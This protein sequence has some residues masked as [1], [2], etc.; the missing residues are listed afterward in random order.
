MRY[1]LDMGHTPASPGASGYIDEVAEDRKVGAKL[2]GLLLN[3]GHAV[4]DVTAPHTMRY[5]DETNYRVSAANASGAD[6]FISLHFNAGGGSGPEALYYS[7]DAAGLEYAA[8]ISA[9]LAA[10][11]GLRD[12][13]AKPRTQEVAVIRDT[14][15]T[16]V[17]V[18]VCFVDTKRDADA[19]RAAGAEA[20]AA[21]IARGLGIETESK[22]E[23]M[24]TAE[25]IR[26][27]VWNTPIWHDGAVY[28]Y[29]GKGSGKGNASP[30]NMWAFTYVN[31]CETKLQVAALAAA[32]EELSKA[33]GADPD[34]I[35]KAVSD[36]VAAKLETIDLNVTVG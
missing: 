14:T 29:D 1:A 23:D 4:I 6:L 31:S 16:A 18:E 34:S 11:L 26:Q 30:A 32:V 24:A 15:M 36:A 5:P 2:K 27:A 25:E 35:A 12:R 21:A 8:R 20:A 7:G 9:E 22:E 13:G 10:T 28:G 3:A 33:Q 19:Y 17:L